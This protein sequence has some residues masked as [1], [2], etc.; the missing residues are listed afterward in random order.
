MNWISRQVGNFTGVGIVPALTYAIDLTN[1]LWVRY[2]RLTFLFKYYFK[3][4]LTCLSRYFLFSGLLSFGGGREAKI[5]IKINIL[6]GQEKLCQP[7]DDKR[8]R[9]K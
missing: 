3:K 7:G 8:I 9:L 2:G 1:L 5:L 6:I 4:F